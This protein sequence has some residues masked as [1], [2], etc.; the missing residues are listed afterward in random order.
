MAPRTTGRKPAR[1]LCPVCRHDLSG[2]IDARLR[3]PGQNAAG[4]ARFYGLPYKQ[5]QRHRNNCLPRQSRH[6]ARVDVLGPEAGKIKPDVLDEVRTVEQQAA[7]LFARASKML[8][9]A[10]FSGTAADMR[11]AL[12]ECRQTL[13]LIGK[14]KGQIDQSASVAIFTSAPWLEVQAKIVSALLPFPDARGAVLG[15]LETYAPRQVA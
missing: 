10:E 11:G 1:K 13:E 4:V 14:L 15:A 3:A 12:R 2:D 7:A 8:D 5:V 6:V 9:Q